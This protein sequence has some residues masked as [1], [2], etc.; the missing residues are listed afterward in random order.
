VEWG[1]SVELHFAGGMLR[2]GKVLFANNGTSVRLSGL[3]EIAFPKL[4]L[5]AL[6]APLAEKQ[7]EAIGLAER[8]PFYTVDFPYLWGRLRRDNSIVWGAGLVRPGETNDVR[9]ID[10]ASAEPA[11]MFETLKRR[12]RNLHPMLAEIRFTHQWGGPILFREEW[13][14]VFGHHPANDRGIVLGAF[15]GHGVALSVYLGTW[16]AEALLGRRELPAWG[17]ISSRRGSDPFS[18]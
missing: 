1:D 7:I 18:V 13:T 11:R 3:N 4:T 5:A 16:A 6:S 15:A 10:I 17:E 12:I 8:K 14:P 2:V 9:E